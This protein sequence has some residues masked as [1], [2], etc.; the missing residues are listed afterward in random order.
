[1]WHLDRVTGGKNKHITLSSSTIQ[2][3]NINS[4]YSK[5]TSGSSTTRQILLIWS[6]N[7]DHRERKTP[8]NHPPLIPLHTTQAGLPLSMQRGRVQISTSSEGRSEGGQALWWRGKGPLTEAWRVPPPESQPPPDT[9]SSPHSHIKPALRPKGKHNS[10]AQ[11]TV[12]PPLDWHQIPLCP[13][14]FLSQLK[15]TKNNMHKHI[16]LSWR[17]LPWGFCFLQKWVLT[18][19]ISCI[20]PCTPEL[21]SNQFWMSMSAEWQ[22]EVENG[23]VSLGGDTLVIK[24]LTSNNTNKEPSSHL[25]QCWKVQWAADWWIAGWVQTRAHVICHRASLG[26]SM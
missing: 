11:F 25:A 14:P 17:N 21:L 26:R 1:M 15:M 19:G 12:I 16:P 9:N 3:G 5:F 10:V 24:Y 20:H 4:K 2:L 22:T 18:L 13:Q 6:V 23:S 7:K 8:Y